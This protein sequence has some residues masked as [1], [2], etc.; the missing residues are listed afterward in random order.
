MTDNQTAKKPLRKAFRKPWLPIRVRK[1]I[2]LVAMLALIIFYALLVMT[3]AVTTSVP[4]NKAIELVF[5]LITGI[6]WVLP[7]GAIIYWMQ[8]PD[9]EE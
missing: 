4:D 7:A 5:Y 6:A 2:G 1:L 9:E 3:V 8:R